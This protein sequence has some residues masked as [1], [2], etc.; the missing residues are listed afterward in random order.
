MSLDLAGIDMQRSVV[1]KIDI[2]STALP[3]VTKMLRSL[4]QLGARL[5]PV[6]RAALRAWIDTAVIYT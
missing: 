4:K 1:P 6:C 2:Q 5:L 3:Y